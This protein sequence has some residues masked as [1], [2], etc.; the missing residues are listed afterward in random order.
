VLGSRPQA[1][2]AALTAGA[3]AFVSKNDSP[4]TMLRILRSIGDERR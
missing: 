3:D 4:D 2:Q 1:E